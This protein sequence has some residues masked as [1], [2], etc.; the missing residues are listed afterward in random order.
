MFTAKNITL[1]SFVGIAVVMLLAGWNVGSADSELNCTGEGSWIINDSSGFV[2]LTLNLPLDNTKKR[3]G[4]S[5][6]PVT[7]DPTL[8]GAFADVTTLTPMKGIVE[9]VGANLYDY[10]WIAYGLTADHDIFYIVRSR[11][12][13]SFVDCDTVDSEG[14]LGFYGY[15]Q[16]PFGEEAPAFGCIPNTSTAVRTPLTPAC[17]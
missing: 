17:E 3:V 12:T 14:S 15:W 16:D 1:V 6:T 10:Q 2:W 7:F 8:G 11:G 13:L 5:M 9:Q 4:M